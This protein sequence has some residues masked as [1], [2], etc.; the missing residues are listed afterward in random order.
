MATPEVLK[1]LY[2][3]AE[4]ITLIINCPESLQSLFHKA[5][6]SSVLKKEY[7]FLLLFARDQEELKTLLPAGLPMGKDAFVWLAYP[8][9]SS[10][11]KSDLS[12]DLLGEMLESQSYRPV[13]MVSIDSDWSAMRFRQRDSIKQSVANKTSQKELSLPH[14][15]INLLKENSKASAFFHTLSYTNKKEYALWISSAKRMATK[16]KRLSETLLRLNEGIK[17]PYVK[18]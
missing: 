13:A 1:K 12:R 8:K 17:N 2:Y 18:Q 3:K 9:K 15:L 14:E 16:E 5:Y 7:D 6:D 11:I 4:G 10:K